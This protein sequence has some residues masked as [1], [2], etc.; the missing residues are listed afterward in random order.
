[1]CDKCTGGLDAHELSKRAKKRE[2]L[3][4]Q[5]V[6]DQTQEPAIVAAEPDQAQAEHAGG[7]G[8]GHRHQAEPETPHE[9]HGHHKA[10]KGKK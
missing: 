10:H 1:M 9:V 6:P 5:A 3:L 2:A 7:H 4:S 8:H